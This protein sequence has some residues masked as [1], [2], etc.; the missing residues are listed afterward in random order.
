LVQVEPFQNDLP[1]RPAGEIVIAAQR[2]DP[3][4]RLSLKYGMNALPA[5][6]PLEYAH[7]RPRE[8]NEGSVVSGRVTEGSTVEFGIDDGAPDP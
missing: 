4:I 5:Q 1:I 8:L 3:P 6:L 2:P 7:G